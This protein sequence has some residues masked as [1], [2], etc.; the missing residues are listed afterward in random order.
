MTNKYSNIHSRCEACGAGR[1]GPPGSSCVVF[2]LQKPG[3]EVAP[4]PK[5]LEPAPL[6]SGLAAV[7]TGRR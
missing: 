5:A 2:R 4:G 1:V 7:A 3:N 6:E